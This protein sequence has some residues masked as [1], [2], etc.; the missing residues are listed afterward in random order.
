[1]TTRVSASVGGQTIVL[2]VHGSPQ[3]GSLVMSD[4]TG[5]QLITLNMLRFPALLAACLALQETLAEGHTDGI[6]NPPA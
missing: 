2:T 1:M 4:G 5:L 6:H 3:D